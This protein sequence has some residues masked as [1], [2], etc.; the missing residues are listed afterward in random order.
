MNI[1]NVDNDEKLSQDSEI[2]NK[3]PLN[4]DISS[5]NSILQDVPSAPEIMVK[6]EDVPK[7]MSNEEIKISLKNRELILTRL[8]DLLITSG[9]RLTL[10]LPLLVLVMLG[11]AQTFRNSDPIWWDQITQNALTNS[12]FVSAIYALS[13]V[14]M[15][16]NLMLLFIL[17]YL[18]WVTHKI[19][20]LET[21]EITKSGV[22]FKSAHGYAEMKAV[23]S[24]ASRQ[25]NFTTT[26]MILST[27][28]LGASF[29]FSTE[30]GIPYVEEL[31][32]LSTGALLSGQGVY[33]VSNGTSS[34]IND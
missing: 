22:T 11:L 23:I 19:F 3:S 26:L 9:V 1:E 6:S 15:I 31:I 27:V 4:G 7:V 24:G 20:Q 32:A 13:L 14:I 25:L 12:S 16:A 29:W 21:D 33:L 10:F 30:E 2:E 17:H 28:L 5:L 18:L 8:D 34:E